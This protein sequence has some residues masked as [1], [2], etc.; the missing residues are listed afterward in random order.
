MKLS[1]VRKLVKEIVGAF[2][3]QNGYSMAD[4]TTTTQLANRRINL[5]LGDDED[6]VY[7]RVYGKQ[8]AEIVKAS[9]SEATMSKDVSG[10]KY[11]WAPKKKKPMF[12]PKKKSK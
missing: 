12:K 2:I 8:I 5:N 11:P 3:S 9:L 7:E 10:N 1:E 6:D 4:Q